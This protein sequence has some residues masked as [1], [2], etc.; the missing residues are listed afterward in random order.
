MSPFEHGEVFVLDDGG[1]TDLVR[2]LPPSLLPFLSP[3]FP[4]S[5][6]SL[7]LKRACVFVT[8]CMHVDLNR[9]ACMQV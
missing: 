4:P 6:L 9:Y 8:A 3:S 2:A 7:Q 1:E 5:L